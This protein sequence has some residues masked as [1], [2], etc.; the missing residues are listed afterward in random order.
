MKWTLAL[1]AAVVTLAAAAAEPEKF[2]VDDLVRVASLSDIDLSPD[3]A[4]VAYAVGEPDLEAD[5]PRYDLFRARWDG[6]DRRRLTRTDDADEWA[7]AFSPDGKWIAFL[8]DRD[9]GDDDDAE[10]QVWLMPADAGEAEALT[11]FAGGVSDFEWSPD[12]T[13]LAVIANDPERA[14]GEEEPPQPEPIVIE[15]HYFKEDFV[16]LLTDKRQ[17]LYVFDM[18]SR[19]AT[20]LTSGAHEE[21]LPAWSPDGK[22]IAYV[23]KRGPDPDRHLNWDLY[24]VEARAGA[25]EKQLTYFAGAD[26]DPSL[27]SRPAWSADGK[28]IAYLQQ[29][30]DKWIYYKPWSLAVIDVESGTVSRPAGVE[31]NHTQPVFTADGGAVLALA[32]GSRVTHLS[33]I[34]LAT[35]AIAPLTTGPRFDVEFDVAADGRIAVLG[36]DDLHPYR[37]EA[38][39]EG[40]D[41]SA[42]GSAE[43]SVPSARVIADHNEWLKDRRL[44]PVEEITFRSADGTPIDGFLVKPVGYVAGKRYPTILRLHGGPVYQFSHE[45][46]EDWQVFAANGFAVVAANPRGSSG[47]GFE[48]AKAI[49]ADWGNKD[50]ADVLAAVD[51]AVRQGVADPDRLGIGG[52]SYGGILTDQ[53]IARDARFKAAVSSAGAANFY[54]VWGYDMY[55][56]EHEQELGFPWRDRAAYDRV[57]FPFFNADRITTPTLFLCEE[58]D[59]NVPCIGSM[60]MYQAL[61]TLAVP[62]RLVIYPGEYHPVTVPS[63]LKDRMERM[64]DWYARYLG[65]LLPR[66]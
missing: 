41:T 50:G 54:G 52:H 36:G 7:P 46:M 14:E 2:S 47:R 5:E 57:S 25:E 31:Q 6:S 32:E 40:A 4:F 13:R 42:P 18:A 49:Y 63:Y 29:G 48:F 64:L 37:L 11:S 30:E 58:L 45:F 43:V 56:R 39:G 61:R 28:R 24:V 1:V 10:T 22:R 53:V 60:Q 27:E 38:I 3:G 59:A 65:V 34:D 66:P 62:T 51:Y 8:S 15:R 21:H 20:Q 23:T 16:G 26:N 33:R 19:K 35:G 44:A 17:H 55:I 9:G 12:G